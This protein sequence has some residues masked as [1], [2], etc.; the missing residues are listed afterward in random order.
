MFETVDERRKRVDAHRPFSAELLARLDAVFEPWFIYGSNAI[1]GN[2]LTLADTISLIREGRLPAGKREEEYLEVKGQQAAYA[3]L[4][5]AVAGRYQPSDK[6]I[7]EMHQL[8]TGNLDAEKYRPG[9]YKD[10]DNQVRLSDGS[11][12]PYVSHVATP[13]AMHEL[14]AWWLGEGQKLHPVEQAAWL[15]YKFILVHPF[16]DGNGRTARLLTNLLLLQRGHGM[17]IF[18]AAERR[19]LYLDALR[20][21]DLSVPQSDLAPDH[22]GLNLF[23]FV[24]YLEQE[25]L[26]SYDLALDVIEGR[27]VVSTEDLIRRFGGLEQRAL[28]AAGITADEKSRLEEAARKVEALKNRI[29]SR[30]QELSR[31]LNSGWRELV[32]HSSMDT[33]SFEYL[34]HAPR[35]VQTWRQLLAMGLSSIRGSV[36]LV[37]F[38]ISGKQSSPISVVVPGNRCEFLIVAEPHALTVGALSFVDG[39]DEPWGE[40]DLIRVPFGESEQ[41]ASVDA[42]VLKHVNHFLER[43]DAEITARNQGS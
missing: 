13:A 22:P 42:F 12:S 28:A 25:L 37:S 8:L 30:L 27:V 4:R 9:Q 32:S 10:R 29:G 5:E 14:I 19:R 33:R 23:P 1:E 36:G 18:R 35:G 38:A 31:S 11:L 26:W 2:T 34:D 43:V 6:L 41:A 40:D 16:R 15:H 3:Y 7:R 21:V 24:S 17:T 39:P 20:A